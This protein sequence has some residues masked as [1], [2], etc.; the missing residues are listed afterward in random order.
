M[1]EQSK[2]TPNHL[3]RAAFVYVR[4]STP[5]QV[6]HHRESTER[7]YALVDKAHALGWQR[8]DPVVQM[9]LVRNVRF[10]SGDGDADAETLL[11]QAYALGMDQ[12]DLV[13]RRRLAERMRLVITAPLLGAK[14]PD[15]ELRALPVAHLVD[16]TQTASH[17]DHVDRRITAAHA[18]HIA[19]RGL[20]PPLVERLQKRHAAHTVLCVT[21]GYR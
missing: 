17:G 8:T 20:Q 14:P 7:Q 4:Q 13:V 11:E 18:H 3:N 16:V 10:V 12:G 2:V 1:T 15:D 5:T 6:E 9:R 21:A 19:G